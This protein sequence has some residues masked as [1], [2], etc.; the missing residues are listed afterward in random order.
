MDIKQ[1]FIDLLTQLLENK[2]D[3]NTAAKLM[4]ERVTWD[5]VFNLKNDCVSHAYFTID[6]LDYEYT[7]TTDS[8]LFYLQECLEGK[9]EYNDEDKWEFILNSKDPICKLTPSLKSQKVSIDDFDMYRPEKIELIEGEICGDKIVASQL[10]TLLMYN[11]GVDAV[12]RLL[13]KQIWEE[14]LKNYS[15]KQ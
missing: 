1:I 5:D 3:R 11:L 6:A 12:V 4:R 14:T 2:I 8:E 9:R 13:P 15:N 10:L 7:N